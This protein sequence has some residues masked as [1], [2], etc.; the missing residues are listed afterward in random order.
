MR[1]AEE[2]KA[3]VVAEARRRLLAEHA[4]RLDGFLP[5]STLN[6]AEERLAMQQHA[7]AQGY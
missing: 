5:K 6:T 3:R 7:E 4:A 2:Y 1:E